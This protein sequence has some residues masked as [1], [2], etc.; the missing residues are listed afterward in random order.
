MCILAE[1]L[2]FLPFLMLVAFIN[3]K[4]FSSTTLVVPAALVWSALYIFTGSRLRVFPCP[5]CGQNFFPR[6]FN[7]PADLLTR[8]KVFWGR[9]CVHCGLYKFA[10]AHEG[11]AAQTSSPVPISGGAKNILAGAAGTLIGLAISFLTPGPRRASVFERTFTRESPDLIGY[12]FRLQHSSLVPYVI[13]PW[14][15]VMVYL[16]I[17]K[18]EQPKSWLYALIAGWALPSIIFSYIL[19]WI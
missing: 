9:M 13:I 15:L 2:G 14:F 4:L 6:I 10:D 18:R 1:F 16:A 11:M 19:R 7:D 12:M 3:R 17:F 5:R 8:P